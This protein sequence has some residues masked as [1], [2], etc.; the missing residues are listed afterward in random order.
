MGHSDRRGADD[1]AAHACGDRHLN[2]ALAL[3]GPALWFKADPF[4]VPPEDALGY[5][6][7]AMLVMEEGRISAFGPAAHVSRTLPPDTPVERHADGLMVPGFIDC[8]VHFAQLGIIGASGHPLLEW[9]Q[10]FTFPEERRFADDGYAREVARLFLQE[11]A[12]NGTTTAVVYGT[13]HASAVE[14]LFQEAEQS[15][16]RIIAGKTLM[17]R[18]APEGLQ[19]TVSSGYEDSR[20]LIER[21]HGRGRLG[22]AVTP[23]FVVTSS[24]EQLESAAELYRAHPGVWVQSHIAENLDEVRWVCDLYPECLDYTD[25]LDRAGLLGPRVILGHGI[26]LRGRERDRLAASG[27]ALAHCPTSN[28][29]LGSGLFDLRA[30][31]RRS[32][33]I[34]VGLATDVGAGTTLSML[35]TMGAAYEVSQLRGEPITPS[36]ALWLATGG[37][38]QALGL[39]S[40]TGNLTPGLDADV[41][42][43]DPAAV[44]L[45]QW[46]ASRAESAERWLGTVQTLGDDRTI[47]AVF[48][49]GRR[50]T[51]GD[52]GRS[53]SA[54]IAP[55]SR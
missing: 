17:D 28:L 46:L 25:V 31:K 3:R 15:G 37:A 40:D 32:D 12:R 9:L 55:S 6:S 30:A 48:S 20:R 34:P 50:C 22:Y 33:P 41:V 49:G 39:E 53:S 14:V 7:D 27:A 36:Q 1:R 43:L 26:H 42:I 38:A 47:A 45:V 10:R 5:D 44:P 19:D 52:L 2:R 11:I 24:R 51:P 4:T 29:F 16:L 8:H 54:W 13:V 23:R 18:H 35:R 21:W